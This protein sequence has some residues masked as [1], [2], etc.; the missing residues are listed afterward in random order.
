MSDS[1]L[2]SRVQFERARGSLAGGVAT[3]FSAAQEPVPICFRAGRGARL[4]DVDGSEYV[5]YALGFGPMLLGH[6]PAPV[7][8][9]VGRQLGRG[10]GF[11]A[12]HELEAEVAEAVCRTVLSAEL[13][14]F[15]STGSEAVQAAIRIARA[16]TGRNRV[17]IGRAHV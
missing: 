17:E 10:I 1:F 9:A 14:A 6:S 3:A 2:R 7:I 12:S 5:D 8:E 13:C 15:T 16:A 4:W 11:G